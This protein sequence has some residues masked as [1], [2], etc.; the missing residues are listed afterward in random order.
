ML[1]ATVPLLNG[2]GSEQSVKLVDMDLR[3]LASIRIKRI[4]VPASEIER[5]LE[6]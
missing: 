4:D 2:T 6:M 1:G 5:R 3:C